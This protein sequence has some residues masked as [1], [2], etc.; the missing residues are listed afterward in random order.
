M[1]DGRYMIDGALVNPVPV[2]VCRGLGAH[3]VIA[4]S[5][6]GD[7]FGPIGSSHE[8]DFDDGSEIEPDLPRSR[9]PAQQSL[10]N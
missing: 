5:L 2:S 6:N 10:N 7:A 1:V 3:L 8:V 9:S 4:V